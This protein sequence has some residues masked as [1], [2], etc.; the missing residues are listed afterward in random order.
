MARERP[1]DVR[2]HGP[3]LAQIE[4]IERLSGKSIPAILCESV[5]LWNWWCKQRLDDGVLLR[6]AG[7][8]AGVKAAARPVP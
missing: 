5:N 1:I 2:L 3:T 6:V 8:G 7:A 4:E